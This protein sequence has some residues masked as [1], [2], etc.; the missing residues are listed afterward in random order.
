MKNAKKKKNEKKKKSEDERQRQKK[1]Q[2]KK[3]KTKK[4]TEA[5]KDPR[6][7]RKKER[8]PVWPST[9][10]HSHPTRDEEK[11]EKKKKRCGREAE[12]ESDC[13]VLS[14]CVRQRCEERA[15]E[16]KAKPFVH[17]ENHCHWNDEAKEKK[18]K[19]EEKQTERKDLA[20]CAE[21][22]VKPTRDCEKRNE[23]DEN[24]AKKA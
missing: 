9:P 12:R 23:L 6:R 7:E 8:G 20:S 1:K 19:R 3:K 10:I 16:S 22:W 18:K 15:G 2:T 21:R 4:K 13:L 24:K 5:R 17:D 11:K 14:L